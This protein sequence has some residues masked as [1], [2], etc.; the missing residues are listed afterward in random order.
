MPASLAVCA[1]PP[2]CRSAAQPGPAVL[3]LPPS[4]R[5]FSTTAPNT[6]F[7]APIKWPGLL[8]VLHNT[9]A[10]PSWYT[11]M[12][13]T[14]GH[15]HAQELA[16]PC[17]YSPSLRACCRHPPTRSM[18]AHQLTPARSACAVLIRL[19]SSFQHRVFMHAQ[20]RCG[21][22]TTPATTASSAIRRRFGSERIE[23]SFLS[24]YVH[25]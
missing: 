12:Q 8:F 2:L 3:T 4:F 9:S 19:C 17:P 5:F 6:L 21:L 10:P 20:H 15:A 23:L 24:S 7:C 14:A 1:W 25:S 16:N 11:P 18:S 13:C 22:R